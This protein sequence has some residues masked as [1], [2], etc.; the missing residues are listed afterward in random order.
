MVTG[1]TLSKFREKKVKR[2]DFKKKKISQATKINK[3][4]FFFYY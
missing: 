3:L 2:N 1:P 4:I